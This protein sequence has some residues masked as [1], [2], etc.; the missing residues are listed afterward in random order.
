M[1]AK[2][3]PVHPRSRKDRGFTLIELMVV[4]AI[5]S[6]LTA[7]AIPA[8]NSYQQRAIDDH[9]IRDI[10]N[11]TIAIEAYYA[12]RRVYTS[13]IAD[14]LATGLRQTP[15][16]TM[17]ITLTTETTYTITASKPNGTKASY[18]FDNVTGLIQ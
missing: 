15:G 2:Q 4:I 16:V 9:M 18:S 11:A 13:I 6:I 12:D 14:L 1:K 3:E 5:V 8:Y 10:K 7:I 17:T